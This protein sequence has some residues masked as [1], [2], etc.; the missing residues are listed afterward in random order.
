MTWLLQRGIPCPRP[1][2]PVALA[3]PSRESGEQEYLTW[4]RP[5]SPVVTARLV[6]SERTRHSLG[7]PLQHMRPTQFR[8][9]CPNWAVGQDPLVRL[10]PPY[11]LEP[12]TRA[13]EFERTGGHRSAEAGPR[14]IHLKTCA[15]R[16]YRLESVAR[17]NKPPTEL[18]NLVPRS[19]LAGHVRARYPLSRRLSPE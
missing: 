7:A 6:R 15:P 3:A 9:R 19:P 2:T 13:E 14:E 18:A 8:N 1:P 16:C 10:L 11:G 17:P 12:D 5:G 4:R